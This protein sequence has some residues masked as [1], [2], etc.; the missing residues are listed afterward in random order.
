MGKP[1]WPEV[2]GAIHKAGL[3]DTAIA[4]AAQLSTGALSALKTG[5]HKDTSYSAGSRIMDLFQRCKAAGLIE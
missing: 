1:I 5:K 3:S 2:I 4:K